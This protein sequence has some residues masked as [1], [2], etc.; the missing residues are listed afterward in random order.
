MNESTSSPAYLGDQV[1]DLRELGDAQLEILNAQLAEHERLHA[2]PLR[3]ELRDKFAKGDTTLPA[4]SL[5]HGTTLNHIESIAT[6]GVMSGELFGQGEEAETHYCADFFRVD[7]DTTVA[8]YSKAIT[9]KE[10]GSVIP[11]REKNYLPSSTRSGQ[12]SIGIIVDAQIPELS[13]L[14]EADAY[15]RGTDRLFEGIVDNLPVEKDAPGAAR[16]SAIL[17]GVPAT[18]IAGVVLGDQLANAPESVERVNN[19]FYGRMPILNV[20]GEL[21]NAVLPATV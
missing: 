1:H 5:V 6:Y 4:G 21:L 12:H 18:G 16:L 13:T 10:P 8:D 9:G 20:H 2:L 17:G 3:S 11:R 15:R 14:L 7:A 19:A